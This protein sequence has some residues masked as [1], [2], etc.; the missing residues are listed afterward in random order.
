MSLSLQVVGVLAQI[1][2]DKDSVESLMEHVDT[3]DRHYQEMQA[4]QKQVEKLED[5]LD[6]GG[7]GVK[8]KEDI[9][10]ELNTLQA[11]KLIITFSFSLNCLMTI[12]YHC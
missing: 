9:Q 2:S 7:H 11:T 5:E 10:S 3:A 4:L 1:K 6:L 8:S 12:T